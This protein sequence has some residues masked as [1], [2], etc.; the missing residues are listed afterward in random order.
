MNTPKNLTPLCLALQQG[1]LKTA[2]HMLQRHDVRLKKNFLII[3]QAALQNTDLEPAQL[4]WDTFE[5]ASSINHLPLKIEGVRLVMQ[6]C[7]TKM[8]GL[9]RLD[10][11][12]HISY[13][14]KYN[15]VCAALQSMDGELLALCC[16]DI[17][18]QRGPYNWK[19]FFEHP[20]CA[21]TLHTLIREQDSQYLSG[22]L[23]ALAHRFG[24]KDIVRDIFAHHPKFEVFKAAVGESSAELLHDLLDQVGEEQEYFLVDCVQKAP[25]PRKY[26]TH[27]TLAVFES[28]RLQR[29]IQ[30][31]TQ[32]VETKTPKNQV[33][34]K[35]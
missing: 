4:V 10:F 24:R 29:Q 8:Y 23:L 20:M 1:E 13:A 15:L 11:H 31:L 6:S 30:R 17:D 12:G 27:A 26:I 19:E 14:E 28:V 5:R 18:F 21:P 35:M 34:R 7:H 16:N 32:A 33:K 9:L 22:C 3:L 2:R 25:H